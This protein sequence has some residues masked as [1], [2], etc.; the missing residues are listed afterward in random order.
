MHPEECGSAVRFDKADRILYRHDLLGSIIRDLAPEFLLES[1]HQLDSV[2]AVG[3]EIV[4]E[5]GVFGHLRFVDAQM[6]DD[7]LFDPIGDVTHPFFSLSG[8]LEIVT[9]R[10][11]GTFA[12]IG[13]T[14]RDRVESESC[15]AVT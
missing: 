5:A 7:D 6:F 1:H 12:I 2:E 14:L 8:L 9:H 13:A 10:A 4:Y 11:P 3:A 15:G